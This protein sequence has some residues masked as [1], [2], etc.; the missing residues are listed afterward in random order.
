MRNS[1]YKFVSAFLLLL[2][3]ITFQARAQYGNEWVNHSL[4]YYKIK[5]AKNGVYRIPQST[6]AAS[7]LTSVSAAQITLFRHGQKVPVFV[8]TSGTL[9][10]GDYIEF[11]GEKGNGEIDVDLYNNPNLHPTTRYNLITDTAVYFLAITT[12]TH[13]R[14][15]YKGR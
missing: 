6:L 5:I 14:L 10:S 12:G 15:S 4:T 9:G 7:G 1:F 13:P 2:A 8:S 11:F 3:G